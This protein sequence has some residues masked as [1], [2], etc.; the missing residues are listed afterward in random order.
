MKRFVVLLVAV[1]MAVSFF[2][3]SNSKKNVQE[4][5]TAFEN[6]ITAIQKADRDGAGKYIDI[7]TLSEVSM[8]EFEGVD[9]VLDAVFSRLSS[10]I[11]SCNDAGDGVVDIVADLTT[12]DLTGVLGRCTQIVMAEMAEGKLTEEQIDSRTEEVFA[13]E[14]SKDGLPTVTKRVTVKVKNTADG[15]KIEMNNDF[16]DAITGGLYGAIK[17]TQGAK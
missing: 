6:L 17:A 12:I 2:G 5:Q 13:E 4:A 11:V 9:A 14:I 10:E 1:V 8:S 16:Q 3:C 15:W 7:G